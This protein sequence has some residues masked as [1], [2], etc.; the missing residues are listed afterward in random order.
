MGAGR[1]AAEREQ[2]GEGAGRRCGAGG[3]RGG[4]VR[5]RREA[6]RR[7]EPPSWGG[8]ARP[9]RSPALSPAAL[10]ALPVRARPEPC[11]AA[12]V[13]VNSVSARDSA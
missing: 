1:A 4:V 7:A 5:V 13:H 8:P 9:V 12:A 2:R 3:G 11:R 10:P 6:L